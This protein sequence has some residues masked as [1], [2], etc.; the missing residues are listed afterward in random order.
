[1]PDPGASGPPRRHTALILVLAV[2]AAAIVGGF[3]ATLATPDQ[4]PAPAPTGAPPTEAVSEPTEGP[5]E[6]PTDVAEDEPPGGKGTPAYLRQILREVSQVRN[7]TLDGRLRARRVDADTL[8]DKVGEA[9]DDL[10]AT[11]IL[12][13]QRLLIALRLASDDIDLAAVL[14]DLYREQVRGLYV[15]EEQTLYVP[16]D[17]S[18][19]PGARATA[20][21]EITHALQ[22]E[23]FDLEM[24]LDEREDDSEGALALTAL[25]EGDA[26]LT[27]QLW[28]Q[29]HLTGEEQQEALSEGGASG[30]TLANVPEYLR[31]SLFFPYQQ[32]AQF[33]VALWQEGG[34]AAVDDAYR[35]PPTTTEQIL[36]PEKYRE[37][38]GAADVDAPRRP[39]SRWERAAEY[40]L[41][42]FDL[43]HIFAPLGHETA[44]AVSEGWG[45]G[46]IRS[47]HRGD[48]TAVGATVAFDTTA[49]ANEACQALP[50]WYASVARGRPVGDGIYAGDRDHL[51]VQCSGDEVRYALAP[52]ARIARSL[53]R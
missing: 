49:D 46:A 26:V 27:Q 45:G 24:L 34:F 22:D 47:W 42:E 21:H 6:E 5:T 50:R 23:A 18:Q 9:F 3:A 33:V 35:N 10:D 11:E 48:D 38:E 15:P 31:A 14:E 52:S 43:F 2:A 29:S 36:H 13:D 1:M 20:A 12:A 19:R 25:V 51:A 28:M 7:L 44:T 17:G 53:T 39:G 40:E 4:Q 32:G 30:D 16:R 8:A 37:G 41:G